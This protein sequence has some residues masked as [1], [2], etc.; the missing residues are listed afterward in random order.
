MFVDAATGVSSA[1]LSKA[2][3]ME[4]PWTRK[5]GSFLVKSQ[6]MLSNLKTIFYTKAKLFHLSE[7]IIKKC[8]LIPLSYFRITS[9]LNSEDK[10]KYDD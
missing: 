8:N 6:L 10:R 7:A 9:T 3:N 4:Y 5:Q 2:V 1:L